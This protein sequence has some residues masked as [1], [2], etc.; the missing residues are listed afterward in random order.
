M[1]FA[2]D[3][4]EQARARGLA[5]PAPSDP[6]PLAALDYALEIDVKRAALDAFWTSAQLP[7]RPEALEPAPLSRGYRTTSKR[8]AT[9]TR[10]GVALSFPGLPP[11]PDGVAASRLDPP[12]HVG[13]YAHLLPLLARPSSRGL[14][15]ALNW[16]IVR[17]S[18]QRLTVVFNVRAFD[19]AVVRGAKQ[20]GEA[21]REAEPGVNAAF[22]YLDPSGSEYYLEARRPIGML[23]F[24]RLFGPERLAVE[25]DGVR[26]RF[27]PTVFSQVNESLVP[28]MVSHA[29][30]LLAPLAGH[31]L[32]DLY[33]GYGLF[34]L[35]LGREATRILGVDYD[36]PAIDAAREN[37]T[38]AGT[39]ARFLAGRL[40]GDFVRDL[41]AAK[42]PELALLDPPRQGTAEG[43]IEAVAAREPARVVHVCCGTDEIPRE[44]ARWAAVGHRLT[45]AV[46]VD[47]FAGT[48]NLEILLLFVRA[49]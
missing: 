19:A 16:V 41:P 46:P 11:P 34:S 20:L 32:L 7:G 6:E 2:D 42:E 3:V 21:L 14:A 37:A 22:L 15:A 12:E 43:V 40:T 38:E 49:R 26:L 24:K 1:S 45:R 4:R 30:A 5:L 13:V 8:R 48:A 17:G 36:G 27:P 47:L 31:A 28:A 10:R 29:R 23:S 33:C 35:T 25:V 18:R 39:R 9:N 44:V